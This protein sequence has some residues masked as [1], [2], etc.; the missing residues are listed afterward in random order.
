MATRNKNS[1][2]QR[3]MFKRQN[4][5]PEQSITDLTCND[6]LLAEKRLRKA[7]NAKT[8]K[9]TNDLS[10][11]D[12][13]LNECAKWYNEEFDG[14]K[15][16]TEEREEVMSNDM[17]EVLKF[18]NKKYDRM[19]LSGSS[20]INA[21]DALQRAMLKRVKES[22]AAGGRGRNSRRRKSS[23]RKKRTV[24]RRKK[25]TTGRRKRNNSK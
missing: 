21:D 2:D 15:K 8:A 18:F 11:C 5:M 4:A 14:D 9:L 19:G 1:Q 17:N 20:R 25:R 13:D 24:G 10:V 6:D 16:T 22:R 23:R 7:C 3:T 12:K